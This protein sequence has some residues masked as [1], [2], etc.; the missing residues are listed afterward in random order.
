MALGGH[1]EHGCHLHVTVGH[2]LLGGH[3][4]IRECSIKESSSQAE[5]DAG[6]M[7]SQ[8][9]C[10]GEYNGCMWMGQLTS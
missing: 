6:E 4:S 9:N 10:N 7:N 8:T 5:L 3:S 1:E 2:T